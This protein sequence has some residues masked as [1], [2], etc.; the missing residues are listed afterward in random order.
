MLHGRSPGSNVDRMTAFRQ[1]WSLTLSGARA[2]SL[3]LLPECVDVEAKGGVGD[4]FWRAEGRLNS[5][6]DRLR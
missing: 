5:T 1:E 3:A 6:R 4:I 2:Q